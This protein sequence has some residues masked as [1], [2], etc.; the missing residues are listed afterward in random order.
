MVIEECISSNVIMNC[1]ILNILYKS[2]CSSAC[3]IIFHFFILQGSHIRIYN[4]NN[5]WKVQK[6]IL[7]KSL[8]WTIT[9]T[10]LSPDQQYLVSFHR[11]LK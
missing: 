8:R 6:D 9:D 2:V 4:V 7:A 5:G 11:L 3:I 1:S 10:S